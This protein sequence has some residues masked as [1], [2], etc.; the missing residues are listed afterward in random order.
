M[1]AVARCDSGPPG[2]STAASRRRACV[3]E[4]GE[5]VVLR[6]HRGPQLGVGAAGLLR[7]RG[8]L[9][10][11]PLDLGLQPD[12]CLERVGGQRPADLAPARRRAT[13]TAAR[14]ARARARP[15]GRPAASAA[16]CAAARTSGTSSAS[17]TCASSE[18]FGSRWPFSS[19]ETCDGARPMAAPRSSSVMFR[20]RAQVPDPSSQHQRV[21]AAVGRRRHVVHP[22]PALH[23]SVQEKERRSSAVVWS[24]RTARP[25][26]NVGG[27]AEGPRRT[28]EST[29]DTMSTAQPAPATR[30]QTAA[31]LAASWDPD[32]RWAG[33]RRTYTARGRRRPARPGPRGAARSPG[34]APSGCG[35]S[36]HTRHPR[37]G[38]RRAHRQP[39][40]AAGPGR[41]RGDLPVRLAG[42]RRRQPGRPDV[43]RPVAC[44]R[45]T[46]CPRSSAGSTTRCCA[47]TRSSSPRAAADPRLAGADRRRRR[48]RLRRPAQRLRAHA[49]R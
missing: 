35:S 19:I 26:R 13:R 47:P 46:R 14:A 18:S 15:P 16:R 49:R 33:I 43:P 41:A 29:E 34:A 3:L 20:R 4:L 39:G 6:A 32:P 17:A 1:S 2:W 40:R 27:Q 7:G 21:E 28:P 10:E 31:E 22:R 38:A 24:G 36:L 12:Q 30:P 9:G 37:P 42:R 8:V 45:R 11:Q 23:A 44:T 5:V 48:G 25:A